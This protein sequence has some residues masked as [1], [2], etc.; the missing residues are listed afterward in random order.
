MKKLCIILAI[1]L[2]AVSAQAQEK[3]WVLSWDALTTAPDSYT[4][5]YKHYPAGYG[6]QTDESGNVLNPAPESEIYL[7]P[8]TS[9]DN[10][11]AI[12]LSDF[13]AA[14]N[15]IIGQRYTFYAMA[16]TD[17]NMVAKSSHINWTYPDPDAFEDTSVEIPVKKIK[18]FTLKFSWE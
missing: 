1:V 13:P 14:F 15:L 6:D 17:D 18:E 8:F 4:I 9:Y 16:V 2:F 11:T 12:E 5:R 10:G 7:P 3:K